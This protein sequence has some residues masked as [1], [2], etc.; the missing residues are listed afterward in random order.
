PASV[1]A[2]AALVA[3]GLNLRSRLAPS[4]TEKDTIV[5]ADFINSTGD[6]VFD[7][8]LKQGL[9]V[10]LEQSPFL[11][12]LAEQKVRETLQ[13]MGRS[14]KDRVTQ[15]IGREICLRTGGKAL[16]VGSIYRLGSQYIV[17][18]NTANCTTGETLAKEQVEAINKEDVVKA[19]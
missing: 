18:L 3:A 4:L 8:A 14:P 6:V 11:N 9:A 16:L 1:L 13:L 19:L 5:V 10:Q 12:I 2:V 7:D 17:D 15:E